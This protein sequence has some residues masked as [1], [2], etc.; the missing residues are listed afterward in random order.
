MDSEAKMETESTAHWQL[1]FL[2]FFGSRKLETQEFLELKLYKTESLRFSSRA[3]TYALHAQTQQMAG[4]LHTNQLWRKALGRAEEKEHLHTRIPLSL[5]KR[6]LLLLFLD[7]KEPARLWGRPLNRIGSTDI[8][9]SFL[10]E[11]FAP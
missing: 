9:L 11:M 8:I 4:S 10:L 2:Y 6:F 1:L 5:K 7:N 3:Q